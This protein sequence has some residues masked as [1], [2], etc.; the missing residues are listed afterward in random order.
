L[1]VRRSTARPPLPTL[2]NKITDNYIISVS[3]IAV[4]SGVFTG[5]IAAGHPLLVLFID[6]AR[7]ESEAAVRFIDPKRKSF[8]RPPRL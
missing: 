1:T 4:D 2:S 8:E 3:A 5:C 6:T 7:K